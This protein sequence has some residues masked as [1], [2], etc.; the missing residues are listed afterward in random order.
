MMRTVLFSAFPLLGVHTYIHTHTYTIL[1]YL[2]CD[3]V[4]KLSIFFNCL[5]D[6]CVN[7]KINYIDTYGWFLFGCVCE[8]SVVY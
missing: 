8:I 1:N 4:E 3:R 7:E 2:A 6:S 5:I